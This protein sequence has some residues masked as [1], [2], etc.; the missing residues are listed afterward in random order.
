MYDELSNREK[1]I[2]RY[3]IDDFI[4]TAIPV[5]SR[6]ISKKTDINLSPATIRN[7]MSDLEDLNFLTHHHTSGGRVPTDKGYRYFVNELMNDKPLKENDRE[8]LKNQIGDVDLA[9][10]EIYKEV[11]KILG[12]LSKEISIVSQPYLSEGLF[13]KIELVS[14]SSTKLL[15]VVSVQSGLVRTILFDVESEFPRNKLGK[16]AAILNQKLSG[17]TLKE[18]RRTFRERIGDLQSD[19]KEIIKVF[20]DSIDKIFQ[21]EKEGLTLY[22]GG[23]TDILSQPEF[24]DTSNYKNIIEFTDDKDVVVHVLNSL[25]SES[26]GIAVSI[27]SENK[28]EKLKNFSIVSTTYSIGD[29][30]GK[31]ALIGPKRM[32]YSKMISMLNYTS[33][34]I[35]EKI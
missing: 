3:I 33:K 22:I 6:Y 32:N 24:D 8:L 10:D 31:I 19:S 21:D 4:K 1:I 18:I 30:K 5:G 11:S 35:T 20:I 12:R 2:L 23:T 34:L 26:S 9:A 7:V 17:L 14:L 29:V 28:D 16:F 27:G 13:E 15:V 25:P